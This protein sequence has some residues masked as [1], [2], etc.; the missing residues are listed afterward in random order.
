VAHW[1]FDQDAVPTDPAGAWQWV[2]SPGRGG[3]PSHTQTPPAGYGSHVCF[4]KEPVL[5]HLP[6]DKDRALA[7]LARE[8]PALGPSEEAW[9]LFTRMLRMRPTD[10]GHA[11]LYRWFV[12]ADPEHP[13]ALEALRLLGETY[14]DLGRANPAAD[15]EAVIRESKLPVTTVF[16]YHRKYAS[17]TRGNVTAWQMVGP[18]PNPAGHGHN[19][20]YPPETE[21]VR[22]DASYDGVSGKIQWKPVR[23]DESHLDLTKIFDPYEL[24]IAYAACWVHSDRA[25]AVILEIAQDDRAKVWLNGQQVVDSAAKGRPSQYSTTITIQLPAGWSELLVKVD[26]IERNWGFHVEILDPTG[27]GPP[28][29]VETSAT[30][31]PKEK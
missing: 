28:K 19:T 9:G 2:E 10:E 22:L 11:E 17:V 21:G 8:M 14:H 24:V 31:P 16:S 13:K 12:L 7:V 27:T 26:N 29:G 4:L 3:K 20:P 15:V 6:Y 23:S 18:F 5:G 25:R 1:G 30:P